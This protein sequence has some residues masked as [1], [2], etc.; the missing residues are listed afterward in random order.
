MNCI[1]YRKSTYKLLIFDVHFPTL[2]LD[3]AKSLDV[4]FIFFVVASRVW[5]LAVEVGKKRPFIQIILLIKQHVRRV[6]LKFAVVT[7]LKY[8]PIS[9][10]II[11]TPDVDSV[12]WTQIKYQKCDYS[13]RTLNFIWLF[14]DQ[15]GYNF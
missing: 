15:S 1:F 9:L 4:I 2:L 11:S 5:R 14:C 10:F 6:F 7:L 12:L 13:L 3:D 8:Q